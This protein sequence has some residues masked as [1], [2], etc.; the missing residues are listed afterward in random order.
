M[1][2]VSDVLRNVA[3][4]TH[5]EWDRTLESSQKL[6]EVMLPNSKVMTP[7]FQTLMDRVLSEGNWFGALDAT[8]S[9]KSN[10]KPWVVLVTGVNGIRKT[11]SIYQPWFSTLLS[12]ALVPPSGNGS[13]DTSSS[14]LPNGG[15]SFFRQLDHMIAILANE[16]FQALYSLTSGAVKNNS[17][18]QKSTIDKYSNLKDAI[19]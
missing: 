8:A 12:Q 4:Y 3:H 9:L 15:N 5:K 16:E 19:F 18:I 7:I 2:G 13:Y 17:E 6:K 11:T 14:P 10:S 1:K